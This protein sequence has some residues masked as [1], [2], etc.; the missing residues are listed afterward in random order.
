MVNNT[1][2]QTPSQTVG[3]FFAYGLTPEQ[4]DYPLKSI[5]APILI[6]DNTPGER[7]ELCGQVFD[8][9]GDIIKDALIEIW[10]ADSSGHYIQRDTP[11]TCDVF[12]GFGRC[13]LENTNRFSFSTIKPGSIGSGQAPYINMTVFMRGLLS[14]T[15]TRVYF[16]D[17]DKINN[18]D[19]V[20]SSVP[21][22]RR[23]TIIAE[24]RIDDN[25]I[26]YQFD[27]HMQGDNETIFFDV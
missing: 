14:H 25:N 2:K 19:A 12:T 6:N 22:N 15:Y 26:I 1:L 24:K 21:Q 23:H 8:G 11:P 18:S 7:I 5:A 17:E 27:I 16:S 20:L 9:N 13:S 4:N 3:P 10:Q